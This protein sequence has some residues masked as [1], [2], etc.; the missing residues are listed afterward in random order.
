[1]FATALMIKLA[2]W[3]S[4]TPNVA[5]GHKRVLELLWKKG[6]GLHRQTKHDAHDDDTGNDGKVQQVLT[7][8][9]QGCCACN[10]GTNQGFHCV[11]A[12]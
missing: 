9:S 6:R 5:S 1:V 2:I 11:Y 12:T 3:Y 10:D 7:T 8:S 4:A